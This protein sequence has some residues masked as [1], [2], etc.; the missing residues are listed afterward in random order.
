MFLRPEQGCILHPRLFHS[1]PLPP[2]LFLAF[3]PYSSL[4]LSLSLPPSKIFVFAFRSTRSV[5][6]DAVK[7]RR[8]SSQRLPIQA[9]LPWRRMEIKR[10][11][12]VLCLLSHLI[13]LPGSISG[14]FGGARRRKGRMASIDSD[15]PGRRY[16]FRRFPAS[17]FGPDGIRR[18]NSPLTRS[19]ASRKT[20]F[21]KGLLLG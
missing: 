2:A 6:I 12:N 10:H 17:S 5:V 18:G 20:G 16:R 13:T 14:F 15:P 7:R 1:L 8:P 3:L 19:L 11:C 21:S 9:I 4:S